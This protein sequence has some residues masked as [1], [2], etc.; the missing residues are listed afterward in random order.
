MSAETMPT[1]PAARTRR[2]RARS[3]CPAAGRIDPGRDPRDRR[4]LRQRPDRAGDIRPAGPAPDLARRPADR[5]RAFLLLTFQVALGLVLSHPTNKSTWKL[6]KRIFP[7]HDH[8]WVFVLAFLLVHVVEHRARSLRQG[9]A[10]WRADPGPVRVPQRAGR[11]RDDGALRVPRH[12]P[13]GPL[14][15]APAG[16]D[17]AEDPP[18]RSPR[19]GP[20]LAPRRPRRHR[21]GRPRRALRR[22]RAGRR[23]L[24]LLSLLGIAPATPHVHHIAPGGHP[25]HTPSLPIRRRFTVVVAVAAL[26]L[27]FTAIRVASAWT[28]DAAP[29]V[30]GPASAAPSRSARR[31]A[32][33]QARSGRSPGPAHAA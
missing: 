15:E 11:D 7:W 13:H 29:L 27:G 20:G 3:D 14:H 22:D 5:D 16:R 19:V 24:R 32:D 1:R 9:R 17:L 6:S 26:V 25:M 10:R 30:A 2:P 4:R 18:A 28:A 23:R 12:G 8:I 31:L 33:E 21:F